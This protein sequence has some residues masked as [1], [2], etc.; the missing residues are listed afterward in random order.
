MGHF[1]SDIPSTYYTSFGLDNCGELVDLD[2]QSQWYPIP[3][4]YTG[5]FWPPN[6]RGSNFA[7]LLYLAGQDLQ[8]DTPCMHIS[9]P[10]TFIDRGYSDSRHSAPGTCK[11][12]QSNITYIGWP[13]GNG[14]KLSCSQACCLAQL[15]LAAA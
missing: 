12:V 6:G 11:N 5:L 4:T 1:L 3:E 8:N 10:E 15:C 9:L 7:S 14:K 13:S 2:C